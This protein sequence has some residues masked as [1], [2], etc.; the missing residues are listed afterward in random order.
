MIRGIGNV[1]EAHFVYGTRDVLDLK[2]LP[3]DLPFSTVDGRAGKAAYE[4]IEK[5]VRLAM[6]GA[7][8]A[9]ATAP[10]N[11]E[12]LSTGGCYH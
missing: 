10:L 11:K 8:D 3:P 7:L 9:V 2:N 6:K 5:A 4:Y 1:G 12:A